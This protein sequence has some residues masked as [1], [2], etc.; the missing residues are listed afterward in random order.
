VV[1]MA[2]EPQECKVPG[3]TN[4]LAEAQVVAAQLPVPKM[5]QGRFPELLA[6]YGEDAGATVCP[7]HIQEVRDGKVV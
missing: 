2:T 7:E 4:R 3:C 1:S 6:Q 5:Y